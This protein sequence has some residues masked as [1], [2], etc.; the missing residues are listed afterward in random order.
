VR[1]LENM[2]KRLIVLGDA[3]PSGLPLPECAEHAPRPVAAPA[4]RSLKEVSRRAG[5]AAE[6]VAM[7][8]ALQETNWN[9]FRAAKLLKI[10][11]RS[12]LYK[13]KDAALDGKP[14]GSGRA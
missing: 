7:L 4:P 6:R 13:L 12:L 11:Y 5:Q 14:P 8:N 2:V 1:E 9:R 10:S 3:D